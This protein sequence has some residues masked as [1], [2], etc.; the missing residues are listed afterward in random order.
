MFRL[1]GLSNACYRVKLRD[2]VELGD[3]AE[4]P[5]VLIYRKQESNVVDL[6]VEK[7]IFKHIS[8]SGIGP[9]LYYQGDNFRI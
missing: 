5:R 9:K 4:T 6:R 8:D 2:D 7:A 1:S 3:D